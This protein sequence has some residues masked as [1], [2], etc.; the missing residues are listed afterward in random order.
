MCSAEGLSD[1]IIAGL[2]SP[3]R[4]ICTEFVNAFLDYNFNSEKTNVVRWIFIKKNMVQLGPS[5]QSSTLKPVFF[6][7]EIHAPPYGN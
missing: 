7:Q 3:H 1:R 5:I 2:L 6:K 4:E